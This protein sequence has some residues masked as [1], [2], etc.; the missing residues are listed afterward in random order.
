MERL[1]FE[2]E[3]LLRGGFAP[4]VIL[5]REFDYI[6]PE[7]SWRA[8]IFQPGCYWVTSG[9]AITFSLSL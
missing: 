1:K 5:F 6:K 9:G 8:C 2:L 7:L 3:E 4:N